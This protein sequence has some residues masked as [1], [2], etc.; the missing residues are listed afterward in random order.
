MENWLLHWDG[1]RG[2]HRGGGAS[3]GRCQGKHSWRLVWEVEL[4]LAHVACSD[5]MWRS[6]TSSWRLLLDQATKVKGLET[7]K[8]C[9][10]EHYSCCILP[11]PHLPGTKTWDRT[12]ATSPCSSFQGIFKRCRFLKIHSFHLLETCSALV[13]LLTFAKNCHN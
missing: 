7:L 2:T 8:P 5:N 4:G 13:L 1:P 10:P 11:Q 12:A 9:S 6:L 3:Y